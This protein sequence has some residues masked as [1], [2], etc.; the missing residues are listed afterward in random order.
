M[1]SQIDAEA[2]ASPTDYQTALTKVV[3]EK[4][5]GAAGTTQNRVVIVVLNWNDWSMDMLTAHEMGLIDGFVSAPGHR[6]DRAFP[7]STTAR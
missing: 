5:N 3:K 4:V 6:I 2:Y 7:T 1:G